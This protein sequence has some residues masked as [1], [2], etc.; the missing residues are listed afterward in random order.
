MIRSWSDDRALHLLAAGICGA[1]LWHSVAITAGISWP[2]DPDQFRDLSQAQTMLNGAWLGDP[3]Y[4]DETLWYNPFTGALVAVLSWLTGALPH[5]V[6]VTA[7]PFIN[8]LA[9]VMLY[10]FLVRSFGAPTAI[11][12]LLGFF[13]LDP[14]LAYISSSYSPWLFPATLGQGLFFTVLALLVTTH[15]HLGR[16]PAIPA[17]IALGIVFLAHTAPAAV[18]G[19]IVSIVLLRHSG[20]RSWPRALGA[21]TLALVT[22]ALTAW[23]LLYSI[24]WRYGL[25]VVHPHP[26][27]WQEEMLL[28]ARL[29][30]FV[31]DHVFRVEMVPVAAGLIGLYR[32][33]RHVGALV[34]AIWIVGAVAGLGYSYGWQWMNARGIDA[35]AILPGFHFF[36]YVKLAENVLFGLGCLT[37]LSAIAAM[38]RPRLSAAHWAWTARA[39][40]AVAVAAFAWYATPGYLAR[41]DFNEVREYSR[42]LY[43]GP[44][45]REL[46]EWI[47]EQPDRHAVFAAANNVS[48]SIIGPAGGRVLVVDPF[49]SNPYVAYAPRVEAR[50]TLLRAIAAG[51]CETLRQVARAFQVTY[52]VVEARTMPGAA[53]CGLGPVFDGTQW[54]VFRLPQWFLTGTG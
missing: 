50:N 18:L 1:A 32:H 30:A 39:G 46:Y 45:Q 37:I 40:M 10:V 51:E 13:A 3:Y 24:G 7:A 11:F 53:A 27:L 19:G 6:H 12:G 34:V 8:L 17:G 52:V 28:L 26:S 48:L 15:A 16:V 33:R 9:P 4:R 36:R 25:D 22:A 5:S 31:R 44:D 41:R 29:P 23:P 38:I 21:T 43:T 49:F 2:A 54:R 42:Q 35:P 47:R 14:S 20:S